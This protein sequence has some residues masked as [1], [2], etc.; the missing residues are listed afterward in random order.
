MEKSSLAIAVF[1]VN[2]G[3]VIDMS[4]ISAKMKSSL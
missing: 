1:A 2:T 4:K 3:L